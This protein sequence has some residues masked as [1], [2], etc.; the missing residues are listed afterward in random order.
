MGSRWS[1]YGGTRYTPTSSSAKKTSTTKKT[2]TTQAKNIWNNMTGG[3]KITSSGTSRPSRTMSTS[4]GSSSSARGSGGWSSSGSSGGSSIGNTIGNIAGVAAG[5]MGNTGMTSQGSG[6]WGGTNNGVN[7]GGTMGTSE[8]AMK[9]NREMMELA[10]AAAAAEAQKNRDWQ[11]MMSD[12][13]FQR[14]VADMKKAGINPI[15]AAGTQAPMGSGSAASMHM[16]S[17]MPEQYSYGQTTGSQWGVNSSYS[18]NNFAEA[19][20]NL[21]GTLFNS[22]N[23]ETKEA[24]T[25]MIDKGVK[26]AKEWPKVGVGLGKAFIEALKKK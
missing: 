20:K 22:P 26:T 18:Y 21:I 23:G 19:I 16:A 13:V 3:S 17:G 8:T 1:E 10:N 11:K 25:E 24:V 7:I 14:A 5:A 15:L 9:F 12:T 4:S 6:S 2:T